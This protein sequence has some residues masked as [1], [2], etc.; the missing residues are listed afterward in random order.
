M[1]LYQVLDCPNTWRIYFIFSY[2]F[3]Y[4][5]EKQVYQMNT[6]HLP[7]EKDSFKYKIVFEEANC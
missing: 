4:D 6:S 1:P 2:V 3:M 7:H 5:R